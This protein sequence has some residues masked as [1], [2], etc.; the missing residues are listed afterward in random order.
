MSDFSMLIKL[1]G[2]FF[3]YFSSNQEV[4]D[5]QKFITSFMFIIQKELELDY[6]NVW[7][8]VSNH[9]YMLQNTTGSHHEKRTIQME[10][11]RHPIMISELENKAYL[12]NSDGQDCPIVIELQG[13][14]KHVNGDEEWGKQLSL[15]C[16]SI[17]EFG[18]NQ[19]LQYVQKQ[20]FKEL[21][22]ATER[23][24][25]SMQKEE[26]LAHLYEII[27]N[28]FPNSSYHFL[29][30][31]DYELS[32]DIPVKD[33]ELELNTNEE[34]MIAFLSG[35]VQQKTIDDN[36]NLYFPISGMQGVYGIIHLSV[37]KNHF[38][39][40][41]HDR[42]FIEH[43]SKAGGKALENA[44]LYEQSKR[45]IN[46]LQLI[47]ETSQKIN[48][49]L[50]ISDTIKYMIDQMI[51]SFS[52]DETA[53]FYL[54]EDGDVSLL[55]GSTSFFNNRSSSR[56]VQF[57]LKRI[58]KEKEG[59]FIGDLSNYLQKCRY[60]SLMA[61]PMIE[62]EN[63]KGFALVL[64]KEPYAFTFDMY[65]LMQSLIYHSTLAFINS[66]LREEL[67]MLV[68][69]D[70]LTKLFSRKFLDEEIKKSMKRDA[71]GVFILIDIDN[72][73]QINDTYGHQAGDEVIC[74]VAKIIK[75]NIRDGDIGARWGGEELAIYLPKAELEAGL[76]VANRLVASVQ[77]LT[78]PKTTI[79]CGVS[80]WD[81]KKQDTAKL[82]FKRADDALYLAKNSGKNCAFTEKD[83]P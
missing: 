13:I 57:V 37:S 52:A 28:I 14:G 38:I 31:N 79:S 46:D 51:Q 56:Y 29:L 64:H 1:K 70:Q 22:T 32:Q 50:R 75:E 49:E 12:V 4:R 47:N 3:D 67:E 2:L 15:I 5:F 77:Q 10:C 80:F 44:K 41:D 8:R 66:M 36:Q 34:A 71:R 20:R 42:M 7:K 27:S 24:H 68:I 17:M 82:L 6:V 54:K 61:V 53:F 45:L 74:Q 33:L 58:Q 69:T 60:Q 23:L 73:K 81:M 11:P 9:T 83:L 35:N 40:D 48:K 62:S 39:I 55:P 43:I 76:L 30:S 16:F 72:F 18:Y 63:L 65:K 21:F 25:S 19:H 26:V 78:N 59:L